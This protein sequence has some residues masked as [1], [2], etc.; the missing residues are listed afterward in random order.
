MEKTFGTWKKIKL[1]YLYKVKE[2]NLEVLPPG[3]YTLHATCDGDTWSPQNITVNISTKI[4]LE[5]ALKKV[6]K[7]LGRD[8]RTPFYCYILMEADNTARVVNI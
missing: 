5:D 6:L 8:L 2:E 3:T 4:K 1:S 7:K